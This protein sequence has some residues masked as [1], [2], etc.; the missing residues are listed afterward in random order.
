MPAFSL[1]DGRAVRIQGGQ[2]ATYT[3]NSPLYASHIQD[4]PVANSFVYIAVTAAAAAAITRKGP[5]L[6]LLTLPAVLG[7]HR[8]KPAVTHIYSAACKDAQS[9]DKHDAEEEVVKEVVVVV[10][11][12][13]PAGQWHASHCAPQRRRREPACFISAHGGTEVK[14]RGP[15]PSA[16]AARYST[17][18]RSHGLT[19]RGLTCL[20]LRREER[21][22]RVRPVT[23]S[24]PVSMTGGSD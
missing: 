24:C 20:T 8:R 2:H 5:G 17:A 16:C 9:S 14:G 3:C 21:A 19:A 15:R 22:C 4:Q 1:A 18:S 23:N 12:E 13:L 7:Y 11:C 6:K 10:G